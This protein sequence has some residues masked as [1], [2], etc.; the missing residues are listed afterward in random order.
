MALLNAMSRLVG[1]PC[2]PPAPEGG[3]GGGRF[4]FSHMKLGLRYR[5]AH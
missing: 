1:L 3:G 4:R 5:P 2:F